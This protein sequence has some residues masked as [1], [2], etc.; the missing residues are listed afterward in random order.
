M[1]VLGLVILYTLKIVFRRSLFLYSPYHYLEGIKDVLSE[2][3]GLVRTVGP[4]AQTWWSWRCILS[5]KVQSASCLRAMLCKPVL[6]H[7]CFN[8]PILSTF[9]RSKDI[10]IAC[11]LLVQTIQLLLACCDRC[12]LLLQV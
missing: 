4:C 9:R 10:A 12:G 7:T 8:S 11:R 5:A 6:C 3:S 1:T 2:H